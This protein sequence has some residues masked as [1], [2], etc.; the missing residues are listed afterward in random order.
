MQ[1]TS[2]PPTLAGGR[3][4]W[5]AR[6]R[7]RASNPSQRYSTIESRAQLKRRSGAA[8]CVCDRR[9][10][11]S[12]SGPPRCRVRPDAWR[13]RR[14]HSGGRTLPSEIFGGRLVGFFSSTHRSRRKPLHVLIGS[15]STIYVGRAHVHTRALLHGTIKS[16]R[17]LASSVSVQAKHPPSMHCLSQQVRVV[18]HQQKG[19]TRGRP[20]RFSR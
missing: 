18:C 9:F 12:T 14:A 19:M 4:A 17:L 16:L 7:P 6:S 1:G 10:D 5:R 2:R 15:P 11:F 8:S 13:P 3:R 20:A